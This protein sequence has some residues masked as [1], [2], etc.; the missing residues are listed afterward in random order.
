MQTN[1]LMSWGNIFTFCTFEFA[2][3]SFYAES[4]KWLEF[5]IGSVA[6]Q[7]SLSSSDLIPLKVYVIPIKIILRVRIIFW[8]QYMK[9]LNVSFYV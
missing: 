5:I 3:F 6:I 4:A 8:N 2:F 7:C 9:F 1:F